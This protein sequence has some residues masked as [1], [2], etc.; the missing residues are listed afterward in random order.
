VGLP[1]AQHPS[2]YFLSQATSLHV[3]FRPPTLGLQL[4]L[5]CLSIPR[6]SGPPTPISPPGK[7]P[8]FEFHIDNP[9]VPPLL[10][11]NIAFNDAIDDLEADPPCDPPVFDHTKPYIPPPLK[12]LSQAATEIFLRSLPS[13]T[14]LRLDESFGKDSVNHSFTTDCV[15]RHIVIFLLKSNFL[16]PPCLSVLQEASIHAYTMSFFLRCY[17]RVDFLRC[18]DT[19]IRGT[20]VHV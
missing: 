3:G 9:Q 8:H 20:H 16:S 19:K 7:S 17:G 10:L 11:P 14:Q 18:K 4:P 15:F 13:S 1:T 6:L 2:F 12:I 5:S